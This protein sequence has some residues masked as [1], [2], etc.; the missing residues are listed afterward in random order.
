MTQVPRLLICACLLIFT[1]N[2]S[3]AQA[4]C[5]APAAWTSHATV[6]QPDSSIAP[7]S[8]CAFHVWAWQTLL[9]MTQPATN[10]DLRFL[11]F[12]S[13]EETFAQTSAAS[14]VAPTAPKVLRLAARVTKS[15]DPFNSI[16]QATSNGVLIHRGGRAVYYSV[17]FDPTYYNFIRTKKYFDPTIFEAAPADEVFPVGALEFKYSWRVLSDGEDAPG[18]YTRQAEID[19]LVNQN[20]EVKTDPSQHKQVKVALIGVHVVG[21]VQDHP[22]FIWATFEHKD[23]APDLPAGMATSAPD[24]VSDKNFLFY[25]AGTPAKQSNNINVGQVRLVD[26]AAQTLEPVT[27]VFRR[28]PWGSRPADAANAADVVALNTSVRGR[29][30]A[31]DPIWQNYMLIGGTWLAPNSLA[32]DQALGSRAVAS[33]RLSNATMETFTQGGNTNCFTCHSTQ[34]ADQAGVNLPPKNLNLSHSLTNAYF[35]AK[36]SVNAA[37]FQ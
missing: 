26:A 12:P 29:V 25:V 15:S 2:P 4:S 7:S 19:L 37:K 35:Q 8:N 28:F 22:E 16:L 23:N 9:W 1:P 18:Y 21:V 11:G 14:F 17:N 24:P 13:A 27:N 5:D 32:P 10:G 34:G 36:K 31:S 33:T 6:P 3:F 20:G 30:L